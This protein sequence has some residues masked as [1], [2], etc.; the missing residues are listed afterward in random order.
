MRYLNELAYSVAK[1]IAPEFKI[2]LYQENKYLA[3]ILSESSS[4]SIGDIKEISERVALKPIFISMGS[5]RLISKARFFSR[6]FDSKPFFLKSKRDFEN[7]IS[8]CEFTVSENLLGAYF[9]IL[10]HKSV[11]LDIKT[12]A[13]RHF[14]AEVISMDCGK[15]IVM[16]YTKNRT[17]IIKKVRAKSTDFF[18]I[19]D[20]IRNKIFTEII[21]EFK[22]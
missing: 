3:F 10:A 16:P 6:I 4:L 14:I 19:I 11:Y 9:S 22:P 1:E 13:S 21:E 7:A 2:P 20:R 8:E 15:N 12:E 17:G 5:D 18:Y